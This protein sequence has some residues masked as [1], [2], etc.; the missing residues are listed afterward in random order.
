[1]TPPPGWVPDPH[2]Y[3]PVRGGAVFVYQIESYRY[4]QEQLGRD[5]FSPPTATL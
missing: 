3:S 1:M 5:D 2:R 4:W